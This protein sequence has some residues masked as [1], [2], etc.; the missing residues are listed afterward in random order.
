MSGFGTSSPFYD[1]KVLFDKLVNDYRIA[2]V[3]RAGY[4]WS[5]ISSNS[6]DLD[7]VLAETRRALKLAGEKPPYVL[8]PHSMPDWKHYTGLTFIQKKLRQ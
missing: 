3:E 8:F 2:V 5:N 1:F 4:G 6:G 7:T